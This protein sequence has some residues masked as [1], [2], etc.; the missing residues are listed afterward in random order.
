ML[1]QRI[2][3]LEDQLTAA[4]ANI[5]TLKKTNAT[6]TTSLA[7]AELSLKRSRRSA[8]QDGNALRSEIS[9]LQSRRG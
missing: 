9:N 3:E 1:E 6:L 2:K 5:D 8:R 4:Q 7:A